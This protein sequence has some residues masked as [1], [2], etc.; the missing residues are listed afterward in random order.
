MN[1][2]LATPF[3][4]D[5]YDAGLFWAAAFSRAGH[6]VQ[7]WDYRREPKPPRGRR[8][9]L[10]LVLKGGFPAPPF[11]GDSYCYWPDA[12]GRDLES[13]ASLRTYQKVFTCLRPTP[14]GM[15]WLPTGWDPTV[16]YPRNVEKTNNAIFVGTATPRKATFLNAIGGWGKNLL[17]G[18]GWPIGGGAIYM[19]DYCEALSASRI[20]INIHRD[21]VGV[22]RRFFE[23]IA[24]TFTIT[25]LVPGVEEI[26][27]H[28]LAATVG[29]RTPEEARER[30]EFFLKNQ[31]L[32]PGLWEWERKVIM[33]YTYDEAVQRVVKGLT[34]KEP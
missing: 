2:F 17:Y 11:F 8:N 18:N 24:C 4:S 32:I 21:E 27:G 31:S 34:G 14:D 19:D 16:H 1:I 33:P 15:L 26:L 6:A 23:S 29:F 20:S 3:L 22:N 30:A 25:D 13:E 10:Q 28:E 9:D 12:L 5:H 7:L